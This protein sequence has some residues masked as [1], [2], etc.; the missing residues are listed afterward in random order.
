MRT[1]GRKASCRARQNPPRHKAGN[2][3]VFAARE[4]AFTPRQ[5]RLLL[6]RR[7]PAKRLYGDQTRSRLERA[8]AGRPTTPSVEVPAEDTRGRPSSLAWAPGNSFSAPPPSI[9]A[10]ALT[11][12]PRSGPI[13]SPSAA[14]FGPPLVEP[15]PLTVGRCR[16]RCSWDLLYQSLLLQLLERPT[17]LVV[18]IDVANLTRA[19]VCNRLVCLQILE[20]DFLSGGQLLVADTH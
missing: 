15:P 7:L 1:V 5:N 20:D 9:Q 18:R 6:T 13:P 10:T 2:R 16:L 19:L 3:P 11:Q 14:Y 8:Y 17:H 4:R 12:L